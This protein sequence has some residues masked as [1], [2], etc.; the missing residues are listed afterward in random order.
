VVINDDLAA[1]VARLESIVTTERSRTLEM[2]PAA[3]AIITTFFR[4]Q[5]SHA[6]P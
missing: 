6:Q 2:T 4:T 1:A 5:A 3:E